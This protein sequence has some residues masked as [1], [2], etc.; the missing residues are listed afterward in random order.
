MRYP[1]TTRI[2]RNRRVSGAER[3]IAREVPPSSSTIL[4]YEI[5]KQ[6]IPGSKGSVLETPRRH[7]K[8]E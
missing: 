7:V 6:V 8:Q 5:Q 3:L 1:L 2:R 4:K